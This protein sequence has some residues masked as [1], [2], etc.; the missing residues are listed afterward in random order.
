ISSVLLGITVV[1][2]SF[3]V[4]EIVGVAAG[5]SAEPVKAVKTATYSVIWRILVFFFGSIAV[6]VTLLPWNSANILISPFVAVLE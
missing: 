3:M 5:D 2:F 4:S 1:I 6:V